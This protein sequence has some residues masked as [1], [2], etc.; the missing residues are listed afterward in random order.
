LDTGE[1]LNLYR[2]KVFQAKQRGETKVDLKLIAKQPGVS[3][4]YSIGL[5]ASQLAAELGDNARL[6][7]TMDTAILWLLPLLD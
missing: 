3:N 6:E 5:A 7:C 4:L 2:L 1:L